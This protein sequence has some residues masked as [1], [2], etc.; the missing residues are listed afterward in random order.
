VSSVITPGRNSRPCLIPP[1]P[2][3]TGLDNILEFLDYN[4]W[5]SV[6]L[7]S[8]RW[9]RRYNSR[10]SEISKNASLHLFGKDYSQRSSVFQENKFESLVLLKSSTSS[11]WTDACDFLLGYMH[12][13]IE[14]GSSTSTSL[15]LR[16]M[17]DFMFCVRNDD[18]SALECSKQMEKLCANS[19]L[20]SFT[21]IAI[22]LKIEVICNIYALPPTFGPLL[23]QHPLKSIIRPYIPPPIYLL[24]LTHLSN[25]SVTH[26][27]LHHD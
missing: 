8:R 1:P 7:L 23:L 25:S 27:P 14:I 3:D 10:G 18:T 6:S 13:N 19:Y 5:R 15:A 22:A 17:S 9:S 12:S 24:H 11:E 21:C 4:S 2:L 16:L 20:L 26:T